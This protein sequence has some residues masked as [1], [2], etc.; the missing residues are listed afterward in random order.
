MDCR[1][2]TPGGSDGTSG[3]ALVRRRTVRGG[4]V[5]G[6]P[7]TRNDTRTTQNDGYCGYTYRWRTIKTNRRSD[8]KSGNRLAANGPVGNAVARLTRKR[9]SV[10]AETRRRDPG[11]A[12]A[13]ASSSRASAA[14]AASRAAGE[15]SGRPAA[16]VLEG[17]EKIIKNYDNNDGKKKKKNGKKWRKKTE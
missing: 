6:N 5:D 4:P 11:R 12:C 14:S 2:R 17:K 10:P 1:T 3:R 9:N 13:R 16:D 7:R 15:R 8:G